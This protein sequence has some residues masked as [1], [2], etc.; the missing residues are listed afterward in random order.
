LFRHTIAALPICAGGTKLDYIN[1][2]RLRFSEMPR[3]KPIVRFFYL[4]KG[5]SLS[6]RSRL[7]ALLRDLFRM[8]NHAQDELSYIFC[9]DDHLL[10]MNKQFL[11]HDY[12]TDILTFDLSEPGESGKAEIYISVDRVRENA[13]KLGVSFKH[14]LH[15]VILHGAL[16]LC[17]FRDKKPGERVKMRKAEDKYL[18]RYFA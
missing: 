2:N 8:E 9:S 14:E 6:E 10:N 11:R 18:Y 3:S 1:S 12:Y 17:G 13:G 5:F 16:H 15:R 4:K 7:K